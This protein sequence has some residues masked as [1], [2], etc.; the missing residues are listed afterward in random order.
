MNYRALKSNPP[1]RTSQVSPEMHALSLLHSSGGLSSS[2]L[3]L[4]STSDRREYWRVHGISWCSVIQLHL[5]IVDSLRP[6]SLLW[7]ST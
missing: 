2:P 6:N 3:T 5:E 7:M 1:H 4:P